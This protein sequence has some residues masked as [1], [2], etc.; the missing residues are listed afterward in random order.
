MAGDTNEGFAAE[1]RM[2]DSEAGVSVCYECGEPLDA[3]DGVPFPRYCDSCNITWL[4]ECAYEVWKGGADETE[5]TPCARP[6][7]DA[8][9]RGNPGETSPERLRA[10][11]CRYTSHADPRGISP[12]HD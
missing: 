12:P 1:S 4:H 8:A 3:A 9:T 11:D 5:R 6:Q 2:N 7:T 10:D